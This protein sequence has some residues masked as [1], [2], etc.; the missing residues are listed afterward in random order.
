[1]HVNV[2]CCPV[3]RG[4]KL[5]QANIS[6]KGQIYNENVGCINNGI[7]SS[8]KIST[9]KSIDKWM[10]VKKYAEWVYPGQ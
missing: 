9:K 4:W 1:M 2:Y 5:E 8:S 6:N 10:E 7:I 3:H